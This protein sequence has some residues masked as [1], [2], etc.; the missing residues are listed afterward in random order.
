MASEEFP[1]DLYGEYIEHSHLLSSEQAGWDKLRIVYEL[2]PPGE[3]PEGVTENHALVICLGDFQGS[4]KL[5][6]QWHSE[7]YSQGDIL[8]MPAGIFPRVR[9]DREVPLLELFLSPDIL[10]EVVGEVIAPKIKLQS[11]WRIKDPLIEQMALALKA[12]LELESS[13]DSKLYADSMAVALGAHLL[14]RYATRNAIKEYHGGLPNYQLKLVIEYIQEN[15]AESIS[16]SCLARLIQISPHYFA[17]L[18]K[19]STGLSPY[20]YI[21]QCRLTKAKILLRQTNLPIVFIAQEVGF[22]NQSHFTRVFRQYYGI[23]PKA[24]QDLL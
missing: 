22:K 17:S 20:K 4:F 3:M 7:Q 19:Q 24:D 9:I 15:L 5:D 21:M 23:T 12:E 13:E 1:T 10:V 2:E 18:F 11:H 14:R 6:G 8:I 16:L